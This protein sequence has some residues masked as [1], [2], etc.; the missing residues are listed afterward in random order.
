MSEQLYLKKK[1]LD[2]ERKRRM[3]R[4]TNPYGD[5]NGYMGRGSICNALQVHQSVENLRLS[6][7]RSS[8][9]P[10]GNAE[11]DQLAPLDPY[12][13]TPRLGQK[14]M[15]RRRNPM[16]SSVSQSSIQTKM[17][18]ISRSRYSMKGRESFSRNQ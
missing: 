3:S 15:I 1:I 7:N 14:L 11:A 10:T 6:C 12:S 16:Y 4:L 5:V 13:A 2:A 17:P 8:N 18:Q 9:Q